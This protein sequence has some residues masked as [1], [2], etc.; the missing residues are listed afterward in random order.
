MTFLTLAVSVMLL[1]AWNNLN[2]MK[3]RLSTLQDEMQKKN[4]ECLEL[5]QEIYELK[6]NPHAVETV[7]REKFRMVKDNERVYTYPAEKKEK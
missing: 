5:T 7:A 4:A 2:D 1:K 3:H 6:N